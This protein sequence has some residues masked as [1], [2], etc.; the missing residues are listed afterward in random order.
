MMDYICY[1]TI[2][3]MSGPCE[4]CITCSHRHMLS[5]ED[6]AY[7]EKTYGGSS[8]EKSDEPSDK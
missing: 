4:G 8:D 5:D 3:C 6:W 2:G 1:E 7:V